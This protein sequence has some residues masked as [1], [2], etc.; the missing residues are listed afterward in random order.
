MAEG[1]DGWGI[2]R[3]KGDGIPI[4]LIVYPGAYHDFDAP[5]LRYA[6]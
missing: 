4:E 3:D 5:Q 1:R 6:R 2:S